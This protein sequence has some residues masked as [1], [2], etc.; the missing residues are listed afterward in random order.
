MNFSKKFNHEALYHTLFETANDAILIMDS[1]F[2]YECNQMALTLY[3]CELKEELIG[4][5]P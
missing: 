2:F 1:E 4:H 5:S 3:G